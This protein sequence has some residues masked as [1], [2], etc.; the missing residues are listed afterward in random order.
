M[1]WNACNHLG[2]VTITATMVSKARITLDRQQRLIRDLG[3]TLLKVSQFKE[4]VPVCRL[5]HALHV[6][7][8]Y[9]LRLDELVQ[10]GADM[11]S[12]GTVC[13]GC[14]AARA[15]RVASIPVE[16]YFTPPAPGASADG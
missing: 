16:S 13:P 3:Q 10:E 11:D 1:Y 7:E 14:L 4:L 6:D 12:I 2:V 9:H 8:H 15:A 5:C